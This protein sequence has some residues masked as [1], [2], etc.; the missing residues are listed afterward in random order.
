MG[1]EGRQ[2]LLSNGDLDLVANMVL[3]GLLDHQ[4]NILL[5]Y[6]ETFKPSCVMIGSTQ[7]KCWGRPTGHELSGLIDAFIGMIPGINGYIYSIPTPFFMQGSNLMQHSLLCPPIF[8]SALPPV[9]SYPM[10][11]NAATST[12]SDSKSPKRFPAV[13]RPWLSQHRH[14]YI[15]R[16]H[17]TRPV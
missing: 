15:L 6:L 5:S 9:P 12:S 10:N 8:G 4:R 16:Q 7:S 14:R 11:T 13:A 3:T 17:H 2:R 1:S